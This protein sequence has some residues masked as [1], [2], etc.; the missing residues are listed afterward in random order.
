MNLNPLKGESARQ[1]KQDEFLGDAWD[2]VMRI[3][4]PLGRLWSEI[5]QKKQEVIEKELSDLH[6]HPESLSP[7]QEE[8]WQLKQHIAE[9]EMKGIEKDLDILTGISNLLQQSTTLTGRLPTKSPTFVD[10][11]V[12]PHSKTS[13]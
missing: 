2:C 1:L 6:V 4:G 3:M 10:Y 11:G 5:E 13:L 12:I 9:L 7:E 8:I